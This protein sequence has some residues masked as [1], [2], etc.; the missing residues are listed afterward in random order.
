MN[1]AASE[2]S[3]RVAARNEVETAKARCSERRLALSAQPTFDWTGGG[4]QAAAAERRAAHPGAEGSQGF[5]LRH[6]PWAL[7]VKGG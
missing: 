1:T 7:Q 4:D 3:A 6:D 5:A 2:W